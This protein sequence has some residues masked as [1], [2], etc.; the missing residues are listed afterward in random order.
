[1]G[2]IPASIQA[3]VPMLSV[4]LAALACMAA[5]AFRDRDEKMPIGGLG[6]HLVLR[7]MD[8]VAY[9][10]ENERNVL[11]LQRLARK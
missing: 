9:R 2:S 1:M 4:T 11:T 6:I 7:L 10:R 5:E 3:I 8:E